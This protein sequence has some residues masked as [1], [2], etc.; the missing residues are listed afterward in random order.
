M[1]SLSGS[2]CVRV[3][4]RWRRSIKRLHSDFIAAVS[5]SVLPHGLRPVPLA[6]FLFP[7]CF[8]C[9]HSVAYVMAFPSAV[10]FLVFSFD[11]PLNAALCVDWI[12][13][14]SQAKGDPS[15]WFCIWREYLVPGI[16]RPLS[17]DVLV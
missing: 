2:N 7:Y 8:L 9:F 17:R 11:P 3:V 6:H 10:L 16:G 5:V 14:D 15:L 12:G 1:G 4:R 13:P